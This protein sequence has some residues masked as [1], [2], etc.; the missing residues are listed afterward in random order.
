MTTSATIRQAAVLVGGL[1]TRLGALTANTPKPL[2]PCGDRPFLAWVLRELVRVGVEEVI[3]LT[4]YLSEVVE[5]E[6]PAMI[7]T[8]PKPVNII[9]AR[10]PQQAGT[11][12]ALFY[13]D[14]KSVV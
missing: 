8:L 3:L 7:A 6:L 4:G 12:G 5:A 2:L 9:I 1:G 13:A 14:R 11:G 10:E